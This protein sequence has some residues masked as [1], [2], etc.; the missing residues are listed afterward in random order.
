VRRVSLVGIGPGSPGLVTLKAAEA[1]RSADILRHPEGVDPAILGMARPGAV[2]GVFRE[3]DEI[4]QLAN[5]DHRVAVLFSGDPFALGTGSALALRLEAEEIDF[6]VVPGVLAESAGPS[7]SGISP[8]VLGRPKGEAETA[9]FRVATG[10]VKQAVADLLASGRSREDPAA[11]I[12]NPGGAGQ[13]K[14]LAPLGELP[15]R[16]AD[17]REGTLVLVVGPGVQSAARLDTLAGRPL[18][19]RRV[20]VTRARQ[21]AEEFHRH[22]ADLGAWV[23]DIPTIEVRPMRIDAQVRDAVNGLDD[24]QLVVFAS[25]NAVEIFFDMLFELGR[26]ARALRN[27]RLCAIGPETARALEGHGLVPELVSGEYTAEGL[28]ETLGSWDLTGARILVPRARQNR[29]GLPAI[30]AKRGAE[31]EILPVYELAC[32]KGAGSALQGLLDTDPV[33]VVTFTSTATVV[34]FAGSFQSGDLESLLARTRIACM[35]PV[36]ADT[37][38][39]LGMRVDII[40]GEYTARGL[41]QAVAAFYKS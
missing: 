30:L 35:G 31:V 13:R 7:I 39:R 38:R 3:A 2:I 29:D 15:G 6:E 5:H 41:A 25:V 20:L 37:A 33:D 24:T 17:L 23:V 16:A 27:S 34:N 12:V 36:T 21:Q 19:G 40:A 9:A 8:E 14:V 4:V 11:L 32:P 28:A 10:E 22:L 18:H 1:I 26:D